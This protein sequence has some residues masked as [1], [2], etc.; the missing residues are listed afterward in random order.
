MV[1]CERTPGAPESVVELSPAIRP[2]RIRSIDVTPCIFKSFAVITAALPVM[3]SLLIT[4][5]PVTTTSFIL[6]ASSSIV[7]RI[8]LLKSTTR[9]VCGFIPIYVK[10]SV[11]AFDV[12]DIGMANTPFMSVVVLRVEPLSAT[13]T[14]GKGCLVSST[15]TPRS[16]FPCCCCCITVAGA[17]S[18]VAAIGMTHTNVRAATVNLRNIRQV[19]LLL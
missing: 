2:S 12:L 4:S 7:T 15:T 9:M 6:L 11:A 14:P 10:T 13:V 16:V 3:W 5:I 19:Y 17:S 18:V 1:I 8:T